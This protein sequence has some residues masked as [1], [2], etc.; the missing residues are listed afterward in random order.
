MQVKNRS[1]LFNQEYSLVHPKVM[2]DKGRKRVAMQI[3]AVLKN[4]RPV[5]NFKAS[6]LLDVG[7]SNGVITKYLMPYFKEI[8]CI[9]TDVHAISLG[10]KFFAQPRFRLSAFDGLHIPFKSNSIDVII[11]RRTFG[12]AENPQKLTAEIHRVLKPGGLVY[13]ESNSPFSPRMVIQPDLAGFIYRLLGRETYYLGRYKT[14]WGYQK[15][16]ALFQIE[17]M[18]AKI[19]KDP[20]K[21]H[22]TRL[23][24]W[25]SLRKFLPGFVFH[26]IEPFLPVYIWVLQKP[27]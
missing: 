15:A 3:Y 12:S 4:A 24:K 16:L 1:K 2:I 14:Y 8:Y 22:F 27:L 25:S 5:F 11:F 20:R 7:S 17:P 19:I 26:L 6:T 23:Y 21:Y 13:F 9:D 10:R 18:V